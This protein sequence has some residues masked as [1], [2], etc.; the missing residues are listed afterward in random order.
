MPAPSAKPWFLTGRTGPG[1]DGY[2]LWHHGSKLVVGREGGGGAGADEVGTGRQRGGD[3]PDD[4]AEP[5]PESVADNG[6]TNALTDGVSHPRRLRRLPWHPRYRDRAGPTTAPRPE[7]VEGG[8]AL[9]RPDPVTLC[10]WSPVTG[11]P[12]TGVPVMGCRR[13]SGS[14]T[15][16]LR[17]PVGLGRESLAALE[18]PRL[19]DRL[20]GAIRHPVP[21]AVALRPLPVVGLECALHLWSPRC[22]RRPWPANGGVWGPTD[23]GQP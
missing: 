13:R 20:P 12:V 1:G 15:K 23:R 17:R 6:G 10:H 22:D 3:F 2:R 5:A 9:H 21:E 7:C 8:P 18:S 14:P 4:H 16:G 19:D 11:V